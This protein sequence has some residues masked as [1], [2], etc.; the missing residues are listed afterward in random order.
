MAI[1]FGVIYDYKVHKL[2]FEGLDRQNTAV[3]NELTNKYIT[4]HYRSEA[5]RNQHTFFA[6]MFL[7]YTE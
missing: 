5:L 2:E 6:M 3:L 4:T 1:Y 7:L